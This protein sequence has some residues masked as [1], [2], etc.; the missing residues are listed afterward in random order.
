MVK[1]NRG[2]SLIELM[3][4]VAIIGILSAIAIPQINKYMARARQTEAKTNLASIY[5]AN[6]AF[7]AEFN[8]YDNRFGVIGYSPEGKLRYNL[9]WDAAGVQATLSQYGYT[10]S[11][12]AATNAAAHCTGT[13][14][15]D[16]S[17][18]GTGAGGNCAVM[19]DG[20]GANGTLTGSDLNFETD[21]IAIASGRIATGGTPD[22]WSIDQNKVLLNVQDGTN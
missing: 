2:F 1:N 9:G 6:K 16:G 4:V 19:A 10:G 11:A 15:T 8:I 7:F 21:F 18:S 12:P 3:V 17:L 22:R 5:T 13:I 14:A 20:Q